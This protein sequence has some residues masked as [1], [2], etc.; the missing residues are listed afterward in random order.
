M[1][2][3]Q[4]SRREFDRVDPTGQLRMRYEVFRCDLEQVGFKVSGLERLERA[5]AIAGSARSPIFPAI[6]SRQRGAT[7]DRA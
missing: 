2:R 3:L 5:R 7:H 4:E 6:R 1:E